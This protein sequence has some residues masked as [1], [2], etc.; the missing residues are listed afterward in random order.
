MTVRIRDIFDAL[1]AFNPETTFS[2]AVEYFRAM[3]HLEAVP[4]VYDAVPLGVLRRSSV[5]ETFL[6]AEL[7]SRLLHKPVTD[8]MV[9][10]FETAEISES[11]AF[12]A[13][14][15]AD[16]GLELFSYGVIAT[17]AGQY[18]GYVEPKHLFAAVTREN[19]ARAIAMK[20]RAVQTAQLKAKQE[21]T[22]DEHIRFVSYLAHEIRTPLTGVLGVADLLADRKL[23]A[24]SRDFARTISESGQHLDDLL[25]N[26]LDLSHLEV[27]KL[28]ISP[29][30]FKLSDFVQETRT[31]WAGRATKKNISLRVTL[32][33]TSTGRIAADVTRLRQVIFNL[34]ANAMKFTDRGSV[35]VNISTVPTRAGHAEL[36]VV[37]ADT[38]VGIKD[39]DKQRLFEA[40]EQSSA[41]TIH[42][43][44]GTGLGL[45]IAKGLMDRMGG[46][47]ELS[48]N[49][50]G[51]AV[52][53]VSCP[54]RKAGPR[55]AVE[56][57][58]KPKSANFQLGR[59]LLVEDHEVSRT[60]M[61]E[62]LR[63]VGWTV[64]LVETAEQ[65]RRR[66]LEIPYQAILLDLNL[67][68][69]SGLDIVKSMRAEEGPN[70]YGPIL[71]V[72]AD[73]SEN[74]KDACR[75]A[76]FS[77]FISKPIRPRLLVAS[78]LDAIIAENDQADVAELTTQQAG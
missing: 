73:A 76:G 67:H 4:I 46:A 21:E 77:D 35:S 50:E 17:E 44:G 60:V 59:I 64:D 28:Q 24:V 71:A 66:G 31:L 18:A 7:V 3:P 57:K 63:A 2:A 56:N 29:V 48:D 74:H 58:A 52:F 26:L 13:K 23:D 38:G 62:A 10:E 33:E 53:T 27:G 55:L 6:S 19:T 16:S 45:S 8:F 47:I 5:I 1:D 65:G 37:V 42:R 11:A 15:L 43:Y 34:I 78:L 14:K 22:R 75:A 54:V 41:Q 12:V 39:E 30:P 70:R 25:S 49:P 61:A 9:R 40:F 32:D 68:D 51:G 72:S 20:K 36:R 69:G